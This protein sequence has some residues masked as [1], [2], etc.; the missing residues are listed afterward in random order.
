MA[1][2][3]LSSLWPNEDCA[4]PGCKQPHCCDAARLLDQQVAQELAITDSTKC[5]LGALW[6]TSVVILGI[7]AMACG[8]AD[9][10]GALVQLVAWMCTRLNC[11]CNRS[12]VGSGVAPGKSA[13]GRCSLVV[14]AAKVLYCC[15]I[16]P[17]GL[18]LAPAVVI[19]SEIAA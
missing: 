8:R 17:L 13:E 3:S 10:E 15:V 4:L 5:W 12:Q 9:T 18:I 7:V 1:G 16:V 19:A 6:D 11:L 14:V 2:S